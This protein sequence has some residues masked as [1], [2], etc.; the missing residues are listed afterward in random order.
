MGLQWDKPSTNWC[1]ISSIH[2]SMVIFDT[3]DSL[4]EG[5]DNY[6]YSLWE[7]YSSYSN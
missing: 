3:Y 6:S 4:P 5:K 7:I 2:S 1:R